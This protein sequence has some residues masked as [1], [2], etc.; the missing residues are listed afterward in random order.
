MQEDGVV[1]IHYIAFVLNNHEPF[2]VTYLQDLR[3]KLFKIGHGDLLSGLEIGVK[4]MKSGETARFIIKPELAFKTMGCPPRIP[5]NATIVFDVH[6]VAHFSK[7]TFLLFDT[8]NQDPEK[9]IKILAYVK[10]LHIEGNERFKNKFFDEAVSKYIKAVEVLHISGYNTGREK[11]EIIKNL[12][13][14]YT[15]LSLC[16][17]KLCAFGNVCLMGK[18]AVK[19]SYSVSKS[20]TKLH[21]HWGKALRLL[22]HFTEAKDKLKKALELEPYNDA[23]QIEMRRLEKDIEFSCDIEIFT[24]KDDSIN[25]RL[26]PEFW[27]LFT[28]RFNN[29]L[30]SEDDILTVELIQNAD[31]IKL[32]EN[33]ANNY[34][35]KFKVIKRPHETSLIVIKKV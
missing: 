11:E 7:E 29:F 10:K 28:V 1:M 18:E 22:K 14:L 16:Y 23:I 33:R 24:F 32:V 27:E 2:D 30:N 8:N 20:S 17:L 3:P 21:F 12:N 35:F 34:K 31:D 19:Y 13:K 4:T 6:L 5:P 15:N 26:P 25:N 9:F